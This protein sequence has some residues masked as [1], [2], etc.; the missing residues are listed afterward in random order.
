ML[1]VDGEQLGAGVGDGGHE[2]LAGRDEAF[3]VGERQAASLARRLEGRLEAGSADDRRH[4]AV[5]RLGSGGNDRAGTGGDAY[6][7]AGER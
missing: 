7:G 1:A 2:H 6:A 5:G 3:L 4:D